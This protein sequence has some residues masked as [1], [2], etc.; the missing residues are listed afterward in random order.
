MFSQSTRV[1]TRPL[2]NRNVHSEKQFSVY[3]Q[4]ERSMIVVTFFLLIMNQTEY[5]LGYIQKGNCHYDHIPLNLRVNR[6][7]FL[8]LQHVSNQ[9]MVAIKRRR[10]HI[11]VERFFNFFEFVPVIA[12]KSCPLMRKKC[13]KNPRSLN[14]FFHASHET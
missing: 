3:F 6:N 4:I 14:Q 12:K 7:L 11:R 13:V 2:I 10:L 8:C 9:R 5:C 1:E